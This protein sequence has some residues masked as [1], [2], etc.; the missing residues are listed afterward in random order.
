V[1]IEAGYD[2]GMR[3]M[4]ALHRAKNRQGL[5]VLAMDESLREISIDRV[6]RQF[7]GSV[8]QHLCALHHTLTSGNNH[9]LAKY[10][11]LGHGLPKLSDD[12]TTATWL[13]LDDELLC[14]SPE[15]VELRYLGRVVYDGKWVFT[16]W[17]RYR[18]RDYVGYE[19][20]PRT[21]TFPGPH[22]FQCECPACKQLYANWRGRPVG[23]PT[24]PNSEVEIDDIHD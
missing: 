5:W 1:I 15:L 4:P 11:A 22:D 8:G 6:S 9:E 17:P 19:D 21:A 7:E 23:N 10:F 3:P 14:S 24:T 13:H 20:L 18:F 16:N 12:D 2:L